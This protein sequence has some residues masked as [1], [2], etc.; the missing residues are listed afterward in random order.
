MGGPKEPGR[1]TPPPHLFLKEIVLKIQASV[2]LVTGPIGLGAAFARALLAASAAKVY[3]VARGAS[4]VTESGMVP[5]RLDVTRPDQIEA[6]ARE[7]R[8]VNVL[9]SNAGIGGSGPVLAPMTA[10]PPM[11]LGML[12]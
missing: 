1:S 2:A 4:T 10:P 9:V 12:R 7:L 3:A 11:Y 5:V 6:L 8:E